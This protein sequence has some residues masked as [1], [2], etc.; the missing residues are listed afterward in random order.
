MLRTYKK[1]IFLITIL[2]VIVFIFTS[3]SNAFDGP[4]T[5]NDLA[6]MS[7]WVYNN[8]HQDAKLTDQQLKWIQKGAIEEDSPAMR[9]VNHFYDPTTGKPIVIGADT[10]LEWAHNSVG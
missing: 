9:C 6:R 8:K 5:H 4:K 1:F 10:S 7:G 2:I 3:S